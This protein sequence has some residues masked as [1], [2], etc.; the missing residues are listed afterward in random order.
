MPIGLIESSVGG[1][2]AESWTPLEDVKSL[3]FF[4]KIIGRIGGIKNNDDL[5]KLYK[6]AAK[7]KGMLRHVDK[8]NK[9]FAKGWASTEFNDKKWESMDIPRYWETT[10]LDIDGSVWF[11]KKISIPASWKGKELLIEPGILDD[12]DTTYFNGEQI[13]ATGMETPGWWTVKR[14]YTIPAKL[15]KAGEENL[16]AIRIFDEFGNGGFGGPADIMNISC[17][18]LNESVSI[19]GEWKFKVETALKPMQSFSDLPATLYNGMIHPFTKLAIKGAIWYQGESNVVLGKDYAELFKAMIRAWRRV[20]DDDIVFLFVQLA[21]YGDNGQPDMWPI[22]REA[23]EKALILPKTGMAV[24]IDIGE[25]DDIH[26]KNKK[27]VGKRLSLA[28][29][30][31]AYDE[32]IEYSGPTLDSLKISG[33]E[34][35]LDFKNDAGLYSKTELIKGFEVAGFDRVFTAAAARIEKGQV[36]VTSPVEI[37]KSIRYA[38]TN[39]PECSLYNGAGLPAVPFKREL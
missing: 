1:T 34:I 22:L 9:G 2:K 3:P 5:E 20:W 14:K 18:A 8:G 31:I 7:Q 4:D 37:P 17:P 24:A 27:D 28:A 32:D 11:R 23:Q 33:E 12:F 16:I 25:K 36:I 39:F 29:R 19:T 6:T 10:G 21:G 26:P 30:K 35:Y 13:G 15:V 38:W